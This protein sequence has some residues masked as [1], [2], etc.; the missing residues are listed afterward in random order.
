MEGTNNLT[1][2]MGTSSKTKTGTTYRRPASE[3]ARLHANEYRRQYAK[4]NPERVKAW[5]DNY[6]IRKAARLQAA[7]GV[8]EGGDGV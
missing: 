1:P 5:R 4:A 6:I 7:Q 8:P 3:A 2:T